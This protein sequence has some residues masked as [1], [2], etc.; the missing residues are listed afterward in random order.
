M[1][2]DKDTHKNALDIVARLLD[3]DEDLHAPL[4]AIELQM[5]DAFR[6]DD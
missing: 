1:R 3:I 4:L 2:T 5:L 6:I